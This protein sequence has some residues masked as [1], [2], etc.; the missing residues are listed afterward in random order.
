MVPTSD[1]GNITGWCP[2]PH[3]Y[4]RQN[5][6]TP[7]DKIWLLNFPTAVRARLLYPNFFDL[8]GRDPGYNSEIKQK[9][10]EFYPEF[11][12][13]IWCH[14]FKCA[15]NNRQHSYFSLSI[16][17]DQYLRKCHYVLLYSTL[18]RTVYCM[19]KQNRKLT[20]VITVIT[21]YIIQGGPK[22]V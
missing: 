10:F 5:N 21:R 19:H 11:Y 22:K 15:R 16:S 3:T 1:L 14:I 20:D 17:T 2:H 4:T 8:C 13:N 9:V 6:I 7:P 18:L 12:I